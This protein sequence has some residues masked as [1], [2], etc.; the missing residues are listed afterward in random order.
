MADRDQRGEE[1]DHGQ[2]RDREAG[3]ADLGRGER[4]GGAG[5]RLV[6]RAASLQ[7]Q[8]SAGATSP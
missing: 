6:H 4:V 1:D 7:R 3:A 8:P 2:R 5:E